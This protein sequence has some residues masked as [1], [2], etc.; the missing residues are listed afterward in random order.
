[1][2]KLNWVFDWAETIIVALLLALVIRAFFLQVF[3]IPSESMLPGLAI[4]DRIAVNKVI[5]HFRP[6]QRFDIVVFRSVPEISVDKKDLIKRL[7]GLPGE[8]L[9]LKKGVVY[10]ND[11][12]LAETHPL[13]NEY[14]NLSDMPATFGPITIPN[15]RYFVMGDN[16]PNSYDSRYWQSLPKRNLIGQAFLLIWPLNKIGLIR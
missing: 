13:N 12:P 9:E 5:Y 6:P 11:K 15:D 10:I 16:R 3:W 7:I 2:P 14:N 1:M 8:K 4:S